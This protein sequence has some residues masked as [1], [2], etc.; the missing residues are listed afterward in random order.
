MWP[1]RLVSTCICKELPGSSVRRNGY[2]VPLPPVSDEGTARGLNIHIPALGI[3]DRGVLGTKSVQAAP[4]L[5]CITNTVLLL[6]PL[7][8]GGVDVDHVWWR[9]VDKGRYTAHLVDLG[10]RVG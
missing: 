4:G 5:N 10:Q 2:P 9:G 8:I 7:K 6:Q 1:R 3:D